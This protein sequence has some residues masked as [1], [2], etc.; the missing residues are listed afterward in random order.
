[1]LAS[2]NYTKE[3][4]IFSFTSEH[5]ITTTL[6]QKNKEGF[7]K[8]KSFFSKHLRDAE[9]RCDILE[10]QAYAMVKD[11]KDFKTYVLHSKIITYVPTSVVKEILVQPDS[12]TDQA[13][14]RSRPGEI[15]S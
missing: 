13:S 7:E 1:M 11:L 8:P 12:E 6:L 2:P 9:L 14:Q 15:V 5:N 4:L 10:K 3:L